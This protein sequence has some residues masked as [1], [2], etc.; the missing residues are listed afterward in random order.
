MNKVDELWARSFTSSLEKSWKSDIK[1]R[2][3]LVIL[4][5]VSSYISNRTIDIT[6]QIKY[7]TLLSS[8]H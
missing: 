2:T 3:S 5:L 8:Y 4:F 7:G 6:S 1:G